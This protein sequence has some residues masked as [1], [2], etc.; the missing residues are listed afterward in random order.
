[1]IQNIDSA[2][3]KLWEY[4][5]SFHQHIRQKEWAKAKHCYD[6]A[7]TVAVFLELP[8]DEMA[9]IFGSREEPDKPVQGLFSEE[10]VQR[11]YLECIKR[12]QTNENR[13][14]KQ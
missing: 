3:R 12:N 10:D 4:S 11:A 6:T 1:M 7:R 5:V 14:Y 13:K 8:S 9:E 2:R